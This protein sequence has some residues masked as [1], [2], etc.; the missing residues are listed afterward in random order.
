MAFTTATVNK[1]ERGTKQFQGAFKDMWTVNLTV[2]PAS[3]AAGGEDTADFT[4]DGVSLGDHII[5]FGAGVDWTATGEASIEF[6]IGAADTLSCRISN[7]HASSA[8]NLGSS[9][10]TVL[11]GRPSF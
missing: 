7:L 9:T 2:D 8:V 10:W 11:I 5:S 1:V 4:V 6:W 3:I